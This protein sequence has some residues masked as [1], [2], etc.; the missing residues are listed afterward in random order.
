MNEHLRSGGVGK[1][2]RFGLRPG[3]L[4]LN[5][6]NVALHAKFSMTGNEGNT[7]AGKARSGI[8]NIRMRTGQLILGSVLALLNCSASFSMTRF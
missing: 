6:D 2:N 8:F 4:Q 5:L 3:F 1:S 7:K